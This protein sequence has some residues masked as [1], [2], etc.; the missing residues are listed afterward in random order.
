LLGWLRKPRVWPGQAAPQRSIF[1]TYCTLG[2]KRLAQSEFK[3]FVPQLPL[4]WQRQGR[5][6]ILIDVHPRKFQKNLK[7][8]VK[9]N[10]HLGSRDQVDNIT[11]LG[12]D[13]NEGIDHGEG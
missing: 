1:A 11:R 8:P 4:A 2:A 7:L 10:L 9:F 13:E 12:S 3:L 5:E 6:S